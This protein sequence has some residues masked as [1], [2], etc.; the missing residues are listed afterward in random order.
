MWF[1]YNGQNYNTNEGKYLFFN[2]MLHVLDLAHIEQISLSIRY[3]EIKTCSIKEN[4]ICFIPIFDCTGENL[5]NTIIQKLKKLSFCLKLLRGQRYDG[6]ANMSEK[7][8]G[9]QSRILNLQPKVPYSHCSSHRLNLK[10]LK[11]CNVLLIKK[12]FSTAKEVCN[13]V[14]DSPKRVD[15]LKQST[16][17]NIPSSKSIV[18]QHLL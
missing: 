6:G 1:S 9:V 17:E 13:F 10:L 4:C 2:F 8:K 18:M 5:A 11:A 12:L 3:V 16:T 15:L 7:Y 14:R